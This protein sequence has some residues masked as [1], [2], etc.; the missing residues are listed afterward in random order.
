M[1][2]SG[3]FAVG[4]TGLTG[5]ADEVPERRRDHTDPEDLDTFS[6][7]RYVTG[8]V[9]STVEL[10]EQPAAV[11]RRLMMRFARGFGVLGRYETAGYLGLPSERDTRPAGQ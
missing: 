3:Q 10:G 11:T 2:G 4:V 8:T 7:E 1:P 6:E 5:R 9:A